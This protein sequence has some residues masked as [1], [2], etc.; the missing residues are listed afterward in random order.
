EW[1]TVL[2]RDHTTRHFVPHVPKNA[3]DW[4]RTPTHAS[5][6]STSPLLAFLHTH[7]RPLVREEAGRD[8]SDQDRIAAARILRD[9]RADL[10]FPLID[11]KILVGVVVIGSKKSGDPYFAEDIELLETLIGQAAVAMKNAQ[12]YR[13]VVLVNEYVD[14]I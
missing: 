7:R 4:N 10:A 6:D 13:Q 9:L 14:N 5:I 11:E 3:A 1:V 12:L 2:F 8:P